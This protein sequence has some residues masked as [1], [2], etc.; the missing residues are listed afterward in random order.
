MRNFFSSFFAA[1]LALIVFV[2]VCFLILLGIIGALTSSKKPDVGAKAVLYVDLNQSFREQRQDNFLADLGSDDEHAV[3]GLYDLVRLLH[4]AKTD[5]SVKGIYLKCNNNS[6]GFASSEEIRNALVDFKASGKFIYAYG[7]VIEQKGYYIANVADKIY[8][9]P[10]GGVDWRGFAAE[11]M[12]FKGT[13]QK[14]E[15][16]PQIFYAGKFKSATEPLREEKMTDA[17]RLQTTEFLNSLYNGLLYTTAA[18]RK[19]DTALLRKMVNEH[20]VQFAADAEKYNLV[21]GLKYDDEVNSQL[22]DQEGSYIQSDE[23]I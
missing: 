15:I 23:E 17:N 5:S 20:L 21:D 16:E 10:K 3:P 18:A 1:L 9:N 12:F 19:I 22:S 13:L 2:G 8:C 4:H 6:N 7:D 14:L 11:L